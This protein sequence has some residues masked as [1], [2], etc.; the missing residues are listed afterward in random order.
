MLQEGEDDFW[1]GVHMEE[2]RARWE[3]EA[4]ADREEGDDEDLGPAGGRGRRILRT[5]RAQPE[6]HFN[7]VNYRKAYE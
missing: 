5:R 7:A 1:E 3:A 4:D 6:S 2:M